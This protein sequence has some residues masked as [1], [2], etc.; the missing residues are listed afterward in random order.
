MSTPENLSSSP[1]PTPSTQ[2]LESFRATLEKRWQEF[3]SAVAV[4]A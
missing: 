4:D 2:Y 3:D 1:A